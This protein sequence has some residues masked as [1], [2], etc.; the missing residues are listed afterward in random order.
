[1][2]V[3]AYRDLPIL[4]GLG[5]PHAWDVWGREDNLGTLN[6]LTSGQIRAAA[7]EV[8]I[9]DRFALSLPATEIDPPLFGRQALRHDV[10]PTGRLYWDERIDGF[11]PQ[12]ASQWDGFR[13]VRAREFGFWTGVTTDPP[14]AGDRL[15]IEHWA[16][17]IAGRG[18][19]LDVDAQRRSQ[20]DWDPLAGQAVTA[21]DLVATAA[22]QGVTIEPGDIL[23][24]RFG[25]TTAYRRLDFDGRVALADPAA[26][27]ASG[28]EGSAAVAE[29]LWDWRIA[30]LAADNPAI[31]VAPGDPS[32]GSLHRRLLPLLGMVLG[33]LLDLDALA[34]ACHA[35]GRWSFLFVG[36]PHR[37]PGSV[38]SPANAIAIR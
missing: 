15:G 10:F 13:H 2:T 7:G 21:D 22:A 4:G 9:G 37:L 17:G 35:D 18:V 25:W 23:C 12:S 3:P 19:L 20:G 11:Y 38:A 36:V 26:N 6:N 16:N 30:A 32:V 31:E 5:L 34:Q 28:L 24:V 27:R 1:V 29:L 8:R 33:E 14:D